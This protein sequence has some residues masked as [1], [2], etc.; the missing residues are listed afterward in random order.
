M[1]QRTTLLLGA[2]ALFGASSIDPDPRRRPAELIGS[3][4]LLYFALR[5]EIDFGLQSVKQA[6]Q[7]VKQ[8]AEFAGDIPDIADEIFEREADRLAFR[9]LPA[10]VSVAMR[11]GQYDLRSI[12][13][14]QPRNLDRVAATWL[15]PAAGEHIKRD[16]SGRTQAILVVGNLGSVRAS[17]SITATAGH[18]PLA[19]AMEALPPVALNLEPGERRRLN[20][21][22]S[23]EAIGA[24]E[25]VLS[26]YWRGRKLAERRAIL[27]V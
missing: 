15:V 10:S 23:T 22:V 26:S 4:V 25:L 2:A 27:N 14:G 18:P 21:Y 16:A 3:V 5:T 13:L 17:G 9:G 8:A 7:S 6:A 1:G 24:R 20:Y 11:G 12:D 19:Q